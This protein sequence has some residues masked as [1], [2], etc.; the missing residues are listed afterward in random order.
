MKTPSAKAILLTATG[1][2]FGV[3]ANAATYS[4]NFTFP[5]GTTTFPDGSTL[6]TVGVAPS[7]QG[8][9]LELTNVNGLGTQN[10][11]N[12]PA[13]ANSSLGFTVSFDITLI[14]TAGGNPPADGFSFNYGSFGSAANYGEEGPGGS[15]ISWIVDTWDNAASDRGIRS[16]INGV[17]DFVLNFIPLADGQTVATSINLSWNP[18]NGMSL[19]IAALGGP[20]FTNRPTGVG[21]VPTDGFVFGFGARTGGASETVL[22]DNIVITTVPEPQSVA[23]TAGLATVGLLIRRRRR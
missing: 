20:V 16:K 21:F 18:A 3:T 6:T 10:S 14:D 19:S 11:Y 4:Q 5:N 8:N 13:V 2:V 15:S 23:L 7:V 12:I 17:N 9:A 1:L 22:I